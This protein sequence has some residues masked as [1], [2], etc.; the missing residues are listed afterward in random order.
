MKSD[1][2][3]IAVR[4]EK[5]TSLPP[6]LY[7]VAI[8]I[9]NQNDITIRAIEVLRKCEAV[10]CEEIKEG[11]RLLKSFGIIKPLYLLNEHSK[12]LQI[13]QLF[14]DIL[15]MKN[16]SVALI[17]DAGTPCFAD[18]GSELVELCHEFGVPVNPVPGASSLMAALSVSGLGSAI[19]LYYGF[20]SAKKQERINELKILKNQDRY[21]I[22]FLEAPY[23]LKA[24]LEDMQSCLGKKRKVRLFYKLTQP[25]QKILIGTLE[26]I[27]KQQVNLSKG[28]F[29]LILEHVSSN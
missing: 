6:G 3:A 20:L 17:T 18:P 28:E 27:S 15:I 12:P 26:E 24:L 4:K 25:E 29:I 9:G 19:F 8:D 21:D 16:R 2:K 22:I 7:I 23:R 14:E 10:I 11:I 1:R 13:R 5:T